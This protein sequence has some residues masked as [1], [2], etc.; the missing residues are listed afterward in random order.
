MHVSS[1]Q[2]STCVHTD[3]FYGSGFKFSQLEMSECIRT[4][5]QNSVLIRIMICRSR[6]RCPVSRLQDS[7]FQQ[8]RFLE[9]RW[10]QLSDGWT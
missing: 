5:F 8:T 3:C 1:N 6:T 7:P 10:C 2:P 4:L 9:H